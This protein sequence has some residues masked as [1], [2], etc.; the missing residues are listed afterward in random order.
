M[1]Y[2][3]LSII[4]VSLT[5]CSTKPLDV[6]TEYWSRKDLASSIMDTPDP[7][8]DKPIFGQRILI[9]WSVSKKTFDEGLLELLI[10]V[11]LK[12]GQQTDQKIALEKSSGTYIFPIYG[13]DFTKKEGLQSYLIELQS[14]GQTI[15]TKRHKL[16]VNPITF[17]Q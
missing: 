11:K 15:G 14:N 3:I 13:D 4:A 17:S 2:L 7:N 10:K 9:S 6:T 8:K 16:W 1:K 5:A 12:N